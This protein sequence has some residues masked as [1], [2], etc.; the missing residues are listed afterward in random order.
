[1]S[2]FAKPYERRCSKCGH[3]YRTDAPGARWRN[4]KGNP[5]YLHP[6]CQKPGKGWTPE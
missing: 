2:D 6:N 5:R 3:L 4:Q 1:M